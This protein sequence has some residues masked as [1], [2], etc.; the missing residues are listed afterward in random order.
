MTA[1][2]PAFSHLTAHLRALAVLL[3]LA[4]PLGCGGAAVNAPEAPLPPD[5]ASE[6][7]TIYFGSVFPLETPQEAPTYIYERR[8]GARDGRRVSTHITREPSGHVV[9]ADSA[10]HAEDYSLN[11]YTLLRNQLG[12]TGTVRVEGD[13]ISFRLV[14][15]SGARTATE[16]QSDPVVVGPTLVGHIVEHLDALRAGEILHVRFAVLDRLET[17]GFDLQAVAA[18]PGQTRVRMTASSLMFSLF[19]DPVYFSFETATSKLTHLE[20]RVPSKVR[21]GDAWTDFDARVE[22]RFVAAAYR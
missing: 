15:E 16:T 21:D 5:L 7:E 2:L 1:S 3:L 22:Y 6:G 13:Q 11:E 18:E 17:I 20:G 19:I 4:W 9:L 14:D 8:V 12:Q 10:S